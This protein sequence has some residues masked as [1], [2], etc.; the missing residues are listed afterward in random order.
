MTKSTFTFLGDEEIWDAIARARE[1]VILAAPSVSEKIANAIWIN[2]ELKEEVSQ[3][4]IIDPNPDAFR[5]GFGDFD[6]LKE[7][8]QKGVDIRKAAG[9]RVGVLV[10]DDDAWVFSPT[11]EIIFDQPDER[12]LNAVAVSKAF[13]QQILV[14]IAPDLSV[15]KKDPLS[16]EVIPDPTSPEISAEPITTA[17]IASIE[18]EL[19]EAPPQ[20][21]DLTRQVNVYNAYYQFVDIKLSNCN[22]G[23]F[24]IPVSDQLVSLVDDQEVRRRLS[25]KYKLVEADSDLK[26]DLKG[27]TDAVNDLRKEFTTFVSESFGRVI[28]KERKV[29]FETEVE[30]IQEYLE[31]ITDALEGDLTAE[32]KSNCEKLANVLLPI[33]IKNKPRYLKNRLLGDFS[34]AKKIV[35]I[36]VSELMPSESVI[37]GLVAGM[38]LERSYKDITYEML[39]DEEFVGRIKELNPAKADLFEEGPALRAKKAGDQKE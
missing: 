9:L 10:V 5:L 36:L 3:R 24:T 33:V 13:A 7:L 23:A 39:N 26:K 22:I 28:A 2:V 21:F 11:P 30:Q 38:K 27:I 1:C 12:T 18:K 25:A 17:D 29:D 15:D 31:T 37:N 4:L 8:T 6:A 34:N 20:Q 16:N 35:D 14:S 32:I 19:T